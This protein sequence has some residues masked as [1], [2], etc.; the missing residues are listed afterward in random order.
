MKTYTEEDLRKSFRAGIDRG[1][2]LERGE[3]APFKKCLDEDEYIDSLNE[4]SKEKIPFSYGFLR[5]KLDWEDFCDLTGVD[6]YATKNGFEIKDNET[7]E[8]SESKA[9]EFNLI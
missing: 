6:Y 2:F 5:R 9:K 7:F 8:I 3:Y 4:V 1:A